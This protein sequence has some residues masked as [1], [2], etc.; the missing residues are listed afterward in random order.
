[1]CSFIIGWFKSYVEMVG[2]K[3]LILMIGIYTHR[4]N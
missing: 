1:M 2:A 3:K 4:E